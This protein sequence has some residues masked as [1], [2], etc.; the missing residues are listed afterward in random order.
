MW[1]YFVEVKEIFGKRRM[2][3]I[4]PMTIA[5]TT[6]NVIIPLLSKR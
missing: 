3:S 6:K 4:C 2:G 5:I 1:G